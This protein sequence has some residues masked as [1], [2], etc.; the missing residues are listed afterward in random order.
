MRARITLPAWLGRNKA[1]SETW[2][3]QVEGS[4]ARALDL[5]VSSGFPVFHCVALIH[6]LDLSEPQFLHL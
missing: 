2:R 5:G 6:L 1:G 3:Q 4:V